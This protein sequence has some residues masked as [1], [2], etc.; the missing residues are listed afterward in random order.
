MS[1]TASRTRG[2]RAAREATVRTPQQQRAR[3]K[4]ARILRAAEQSFSRVGYAHTTIAR[5]A[6]LA[7]VSVGTVYA[8]FVD[9]DDVLKHLLTQHVEMLLQPAEALVRNL[10][11]AATIG[12]TLTA[13][14]RESLRTHTAHAGLHR[15]FT[16]RIMQ[17]AKLRELAGVF[18]ERG[19]QLGRTLVTRF[20]GARARADLEASAQ[21]LIGLLEF[22]THIGVLYPS[23]VTP[24]RACAVGCAMLCAYFAA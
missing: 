24:H 9:K 16:E 11:P 2:A 7:R 1:H 13:L 18:R 15:V 10:P 12:P 23:Q 4:V 22:C 14:V 19:L 20:G 17:D 3:A 8:Y 5:I 21:V 6:R